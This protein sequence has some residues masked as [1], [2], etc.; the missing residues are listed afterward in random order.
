MKHL[1][2]LQSYLP[3]P[4][5]LAADA[6]LTTAV[7]SASAASSAAFDA[8]LKRTCLMVPPLCPWY[9]TVSYIG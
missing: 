4:Y 5:A 1:A 7:A 8:A 6:V 9:M 2:Q 3:D